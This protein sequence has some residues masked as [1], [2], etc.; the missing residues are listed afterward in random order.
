MIRIRDTETKSRPMVNVGLGNLDA[1]EKISKE[2]LS[3]EV[4]LKALSEV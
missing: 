4:D 1:D 3:N 2:L